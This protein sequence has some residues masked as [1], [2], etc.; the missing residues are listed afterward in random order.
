[1]ALTL[2]QLVQRT[3]RRLGIQ[4]PATVIG[5]Q[6][7]ALLLELAQ[8]TGEDLLKRHEWQIL[9][10][11][12]TFAGAATKTLATDHDRFA[13]PGEGELWDLSLRC[14]CKGPLGIR[15]W[16]RIQAEAIA[17]SSPPYWTLRSKII[18]LFP[19]PAA[20]VNYY[21]TY[22]KKNWIYTGADT[23]PSRDTFLLD[24]D[25]NVFPDDCMR[26]GM[27]WKYREA[28]GFDYSE[29]L[30]DYERAVERAVS[31]DRGPR[32]INTASGF[33]ASEHLDTFYGG[34]IA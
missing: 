6:S 31:R 19:T 30:S 21:Y 25:T 16:D 34:V 33:D 8:E 12:V 26:F 9:Q 22:I 15:A 3:A 13:G 20:S 23:S 2:L 7:G 29:A 24:A 10:G 1:M 32:E 4:V 28:K 27:R 17:A 18:N 11:S 5:S 14:Q